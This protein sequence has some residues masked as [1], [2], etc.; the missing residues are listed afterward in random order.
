MQHHLTFPIEPKP[1]PRPRLSKFGHAYASKDYRTYLDDLAAKAR[2]QWPGLALVGP[3]AVTIMVLCRRPKTSKLDAPKP[4]WDNYAKGVCD[5]MNKIVYE[6]DTQ[7]VDA[8]VQK[9]WALPGEDGR[10]VVTIGP[11]YV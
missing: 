7:V 11:A 10:I 8:F 4:D 6:D 5:A 9:R 1:T 3:L 2:E